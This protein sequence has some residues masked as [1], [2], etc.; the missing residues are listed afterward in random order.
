LYVENVD[1]ERIRLRRCNE[2]LQRYKVMVI[3]KEMI[4]GVLS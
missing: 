3:P 1:D 4:C 2:K